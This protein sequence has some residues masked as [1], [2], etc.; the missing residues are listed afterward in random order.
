MYPLHHPLPLIMMI[1]LMMTQQVLKQRNSI[2]QGCWTSQ[3]VA[4]RSPNN[5]GRPNN[6]GRSTSRGVSIR[7]YGR[8]VNQTD[9]P[10]RLHYV[11]MFNISG[12]HQHKLFF[13]I[14]VPPLLCHDLC[15]IQVHP[16]IH[17]KFSNKSSVK[18]ANKTGTTCSG[19]SPDHY[20]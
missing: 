19:T 20:Y 5:I 18:P 10:Q 4:T 1:K 7:R 15:G 16:A 17:K 8:C 6:T 2:L 13:P 3:Q 11:N 12:A 9:V 14:F